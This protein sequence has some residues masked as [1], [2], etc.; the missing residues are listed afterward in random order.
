MGAPG[1]RRD[2]SRHG[3]ARAGQQAGPALRRIGGRAHRQAGPVQTEGRQE[4][5]RASGCRNERGGSLR[6]PFLVGENSKGK[7]MSTVENRG[8]GRQ[9]KL[10]M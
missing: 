3:S 8:R 6:R 2:A 5:V 1:A 9:H 10:I 7:K 4:V